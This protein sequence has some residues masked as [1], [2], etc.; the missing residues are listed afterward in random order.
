MFSLPMCGIFF[1]NMWVL[2]GKSLSN[3]YTRFKFFSPSLFVPFWHC[4]FFHELIAMCL[5]GELIPCVFPRCRTWKGRSAWRERD[6]WMGANSSFCFACLLC[7]MSLLTSSRYHSDT[8]I[9]QRERGSR[10]KNLKGK[11][12]HPL[13]HMKW[14]PFWNVNIKKICHKY[15]DIP[16]CVLVLHGFML[17][18]TVY[19]TYSGQ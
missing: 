1:L 17:F 19:S 6:L 5:S 9:T 16:N 13:C 14:K 18:E 4:N 11:E 3:W 10:I 7:E 12:N 15:K 2:F 8:L